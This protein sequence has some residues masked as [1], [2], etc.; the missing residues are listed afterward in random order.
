MANRLR[1]VLFR[2]P[3]ATGHSS[4]AKTLL[5]GS[6]GQP[7]A[8]AL[9]R[10][11]TRPPMPGTPVGSKRPPRERSPRASAAQPSR[12]FCPVP[13]CLAQTQPAPAGGRVG[14][15]C[16]TTSTLTWPAHYKGRCPSLGC[17][18][19]TGRAAQCV[20]SVFLKATASTRPVARGEG[21]SC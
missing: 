2:T 7:E 21:C 20:A 8:I 10:P 9:A 11:R 18:R 1:A 17:G 6:G 15:P 13:S 19:R 14:I 3:S 16:A 4:P 12:V 5:P